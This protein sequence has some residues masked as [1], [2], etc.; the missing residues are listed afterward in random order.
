MPANFQTD[1]K[2]YTN[3]SSR[4][5]VNNPDFNPAVDLVSEDELMLIKEHIDKWKDLIEYFRWYPDLFYDLIKPNEGK[6]IRLGIDQRIMLRCLARF[7]STYGVLPRGTGKCVTKDTLLLTTDGIKEIGSVFDYQSDNVETLREIDLDIVNRYGD[8]EKTFKGV[9][10]GKKPTIRIKTEDGFQIEGTHNHPI[11]VMNEDGDI[12]FKR[13]DKIRYG[14]YVCIRRGDNVWG[15]SL[16][17]DVT[18]KIK[19]WLSQR[20]ENQNRKL[21]VRDL[22]I[23]MTE[24]VAY[25][26]GLLIGDGCLGFEKQIG[27]SNIDEEVL[28]RFFS[29]AK[30]VFGV[31]YIRQSNKNDYYIF[32]I[33]LRKYLE[34]IGLGYV[35]SWEK[36]IP[37]CIMTAPKNIVVKALQG[38]FDTDGCGEKTGVTYSSVSYKLIH[39]VQ[40][41]MLNFGIVSTVRSKEDRFGHK[42]FTLGIYGENIEIF[43]KEIGFLCDKKKQRAILLQE[44]KHNTNRDIIPFQ[45]GY[46]RDVYPYVAKDRHC[47]LYHCG[48]AC[49]N[50]MT[51]YRLRQLLNGN[52][53]DYPHKKHFEEL[54]ALHYYYSKVGTIEYDETDVYDI[55]TEETHSFVANG[56][57]N[58]NTMLAMMYAFH[59]C[60]F[61][62]TVEVAL[63]AQTRENSAKLI[64]DKYDELLNAFPMLR[65]E[66]YSAKFSNDV[67][68]VVFHNGSKL[69]NIAN[70]QSSKGKHVQRG[71]VDED[72]LTNEEIYQDVLEPIFT[73]VPRVTCGRNGLVD[74]FEL[75]GQ[76]SQLTSAGFR[77]SAAFFRCLHHYHNMIECKGEYCIGAGWELACH[78][79]RGATKTEILKKQQTMSSVAFDMNYRG[80]W[81]GASDNA[82]VSMTKLMDCRNLAEPEFKAQDGFDY[83]LGVDVARSDKASNNQSAISVLKIIRT[84]AGKIKEVQLVNLITSEGTLDFSAFATDVKKIDRLFSPKAIV[85]DENGIGRG[86]CDFLVKETID[87]YTG[88]NLGCLATMNSERIPDDPEA[89]K[90]I[91]CYVAQKYDNE[92]IPNFIDCVETGKLR[93]LVKK[94]FSAYVMDDEEFASKAMPFFQTNSFVEEVSNLKLEHLGNNGLRV[95]QI[96]RKVNKDRYSAVQYPLWY[97]M[98]YMDNMV[99]ADENDDLEFLSQFIN[100]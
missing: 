10:S 87:P 56:F 1:N 90:K 17:I 50:D 13:L 66:I 45:F 100:W 34:Y 28:D 37:Q 49:D 24:D 42:S 3:K 96:A 60:I 39:Q 26:I 59:T 18:D 31:H 22:P 2:K 70:Q 5:N 25:F 40:T 19:E 11:L 47:F 69:C 61:Y 6:T 62:P 9:Y 23:Y 79:G 44:K 64:K 8:K 21:R 76:I 43:N 32:D 29:I 72:N 85:V 89:P 74:P 30:N 7:K 82:L 83:V 86:L 15:K 57:V 16:N 51:Y 73:T 63:T 35:G 80:V 38:L 95:K 52:Y 94:E 12:E 27:F 97:I 77:G 92:S 46:C 99:I 41:L 36:E 54:N 93:L 78:F 14:D 65:E 71:I 53:G 58:H 67:A 48:K 91:F 84:Q 75:N 98:K 81:T 55:Q 4:V 68:E 20:G 88:E 33:Y